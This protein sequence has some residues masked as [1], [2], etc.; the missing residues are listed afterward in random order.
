MYRSGTSGVAVRPANHAE[1]VADT[2]G[3][4]IVRLA[5]AD[6]KL[7]DR[8]ARFWITTPKTAKARVIHVAG[9]SAVSTL[10]S[11]CRPSDTT[12]KVAASIPNTMP[13][14]APYRGAFYWE[15]RPHSTSTAIAT[16]EPAHTSVHEAT[17]PWR[18][19]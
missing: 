15:R 16:A 8:R 4:A 11:A 13:A 3:V 6:P 14:A 12:F 19:S 18:V 1:V 10:K 5:C 7:P 2:N 17:L 9:R